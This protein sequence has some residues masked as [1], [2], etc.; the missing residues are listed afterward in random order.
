MV[1]AGRDKLAGG[2][3][4]CAAFVFIISV[5]WGQE[6][7]HA[8]KP[9]E[10]TLRLQRITFHVTCPNTG[11]LNDITIA[12]SGLESGNST[13]TASNANG[14]VTGV[15]AADLDN[16]GSPE[17]YIYLTSAGSG[18][19]GSVLAYG[20][21]R[22]KSLTGIYVPPLSRSMECSAGYMGHDRFCVV[23]NR[24][25][26]LFPVYSKGDSNARPV[27]GVRLVEYR[28]VAGEAGWILQ[29]VKCSRD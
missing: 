26:R 5:F 19:Y 16:D 3:F 15:E 13:I 21:N 28:L 27:G 2:V 14:I 11:S 7:L 6:A 24:L 20:V 17:I 1:Q 23:G 12:V 10:I 18:S 29:P 8:A 25:A 22:L 4:F 9:F